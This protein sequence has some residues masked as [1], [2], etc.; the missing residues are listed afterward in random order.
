MFFL[1]PD[2]D[3]VWSNSDNEGDALVFLVGDILWMRHRLPQIVWTAACSSVFYADYMHYKRQPQYYYTR[4]MLGVSN[5]F[6]ETAFPL[7][8]L[9]KGEYFRWQ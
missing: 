4:L 7:E 6:S 5:A 3:A 1:H 9:R 2:R 8:V